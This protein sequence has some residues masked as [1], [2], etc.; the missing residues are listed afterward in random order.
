M[1]QLFSETP[2]LHLERDREIGWLKNC[3]VRQLLVGRVPALGVVVE[4]VK[5][6]KEAFQAARNVQK[7]RKNGRFPA[8]VKLKIAKNAVFYFKVLSKMYS[9]DVF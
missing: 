4:G 5:E 7:R 3:L 2:H 9:Q 6:V 8:L 1:P